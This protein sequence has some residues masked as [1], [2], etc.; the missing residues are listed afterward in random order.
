M[1]NNWMIF[2][3]MLAPYKHN[4]L[5]AICLM[6]ILLFIVE[7]DTEYVVSLKAT[8]NVGVSPPI[9]A[10]VRTSLELE[11]AADPDT[12]N[13]SVGVRANLLS[14][15]SVNMT[16]VDPNTDTGPNITY[17]VR[18]RPESPDLRNGS[19]FIAR[20]TSVPWLLLQGLL[21]NTVYEFIVRIQDGDRESRPKW[22]SL[23]TF[24][25]PNGTSLKS[26]YRCL[27]NIR[28]HECLQ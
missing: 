12:L 20:E 5:M 1:Y 9:S 2:R 8:N 26:K 23:I 7:P 11:E 10:T 17:T 27:R 15:T 19:R 6:I 24:R 28:S 14:P 25:T 21:P 4:V 3:L 13:P 22:S 16:W 18:Y